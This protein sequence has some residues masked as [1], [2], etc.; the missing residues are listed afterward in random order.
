MGSSADENKPPAV[1]AG[2][3]PALYASD[4][5]EPQRLARLLDSPSYVLA[6]DDHEFIMKHDLRSVRLQIELMK[7]EL[8][9]RA[10][11]IRS[12]IVVFGG[13]RITAP[14]VARARVEA[15]EKE[16]QEHGPSPELE[17]RLAV[18]RRVL[19][20]ARY[21]EEAREFG[22][23]ASKLGQ[24]AISRDWVVV[25]GGGPG[26]ME[27][28]N[29]GA[30]DVG[31]RSIGLNIT[32]PHEQHPNSY[33]TPDLCFRFH[34]FAIRKMHFMLRAKALV[35]FPGGYGTFD[36]LFEA[37]TL[38]QTHKMRALP[39]VLV[40]REF[41]ENA[42]NFRYLVEEG[43]ISEEDL[44]LFRFAETAAE[45]W[46]I[47]QSYHARPKSQNSGPERRP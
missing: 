8:S 35:A 31:A 33:I 13:T 26:I 34:Y 22:R 27:A 24:T 16:R 1:P 25:T 41:W 11:R 23:L 15:L 2:E 20:K 46:D 28:A 32:L 4:P 19:A 45:A 9:L 39:V 17:K 5:D 3:P 40:G 47:V 30:F 12:T 29:R 10:H 21:Y 43:T 6:F 18:A 44:Q 42:V 36:E 7:P 38:L 14:D 37:L